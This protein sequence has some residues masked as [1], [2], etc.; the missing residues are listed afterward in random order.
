MRMRLVLDASAEITLAGGLDQGR[1]RLLEHLQRLADPARQASRPRIARQ[2]Y[3]PGP[4]PCPVTATR[5]RVD[6]VAHLAAG[7]LGIVVDG[8]F[9]G[10]HVERLDLRQDSVE[11]GQHGRDALLAQPLLHGVGVVGPA[12]R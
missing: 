8:L 6:H 5:K 4:T 2:S 9:Q 12:T 3:R 11:L 7:P 1:R 10:R